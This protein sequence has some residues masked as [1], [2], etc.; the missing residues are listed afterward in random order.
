MRYEKDRLRQAEISCEPKIG[1]EKLAYGAV[2]AGL[3]CLVVASFDKVMSEHVKVDGVLVKK[4]VQQCLNVTALGVHGFDCSQ[5]QYDSVCGVTFKMPDEELSFNVPRSC[6]G[7][8]VGDLYAIEK[9][10]SPLGIAGFLRTRTS[11]Q[12]NLD[13]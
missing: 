7:F 2:A 8:D 11:F 1:T 4:Q 5:G 12:K 3:L 6:S 10:K 13:S 9:V